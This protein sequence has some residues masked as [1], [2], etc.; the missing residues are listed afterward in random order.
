[1]ETL[2]ATL[3]IFTEA[4]GAW[5]SRWAHVIAGITWIGL[6]YYFN[7]VQGPA[8]AQFDPNSRSVATDKLA[9]RALWWFRWSAF[10]TFLMGILILYFQPFGDGRQLFEMDYLKTGQGISILTGALM[11]TIM[12]LNVWGAIWPRQK[13][14]IANARN[15]LA[16][17]EADPRAATAARSGLLPSRQNTIFSFPM[18]MFMVGTS[19]F[20]GAYQT[21][22]GSDRAIYWV[23][24]LV[25]IA[26]LELNALGVFGTSPGGLRWIYDDHKNAIATGIVLMLCWYGLWEVLFR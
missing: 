10:A 12:M 4:G 26:L 16:G 8:F 3:E 5:I 18:L 23:I 13:I 7:F 6:L 25:A 19:H 9:S 1:M 11:G 2:G 15:V 20:F 22:S 14:I 17:G 24:T 21:G